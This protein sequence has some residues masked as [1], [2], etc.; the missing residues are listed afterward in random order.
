MIMTQC[1]I[2][3]GARLWHTS[4]C[5]PGPAPAARA[6][7]AARRP[8]FESGLLGIRAIGSGNVALSS[9]SGAPLALPLGW[10]IGH[11]GFAQ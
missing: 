5:P 7:A 2:R 8:G 3:C 11:S 9:P 6:A 4:Q 1:K 10:Q